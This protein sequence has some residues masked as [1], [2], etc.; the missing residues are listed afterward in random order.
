MALSPSYRAALNWYSGAFATA[1][2]PEIGLVAEWKICWPPVARAIADS[3][4][5]AYA[6]G[7]AKEDFFT[8]FMSAV[9]CKVFAFDP[10]AN[11]KRH[12]MP[13]VEFHHWGLRTGA[14]NMSAEKAFSGLYGTTNKGK[15]LS[16]RELQHRLGHDDGR[17]ITLM[18]MD[19]EGCEWEVWREIYATSGPKG[20][21][22]FGQILTELH[23]ASTLRF[24][25]AK[26]A[27]M[28]PLWSELVS[29][30]K[31]AVF[32]SGINPGAP[33]DQNSLDPTVF[34]TQGRLGFCCRE[35]SLASPPALSVARKPGHG[36][37]ARVLPAPC[38]EHSCKNAVTHEARRSAKMK[39]M[40]A[41]ESERHLHKRHTPEYATKLVGIVYKYSA[42]VRAAAVEAATRL[43]TE[44]VERVER[45]AESEAPAAERLRVGLYAQECNT[46]STPQ[47][48][49][50]AV[51]VLRR[52]GERRTTTRE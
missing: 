38:C 28:V 11:H 23:F 18:K 36:R 22:P 19:C 12:W 20:L 48:S 45:A 40:N 24:T 41:S 50:I 25:A 37:A 10:S 17:H 43:K 16:L 27:K 34:G 14:A 26:A 13:N 21:A 35:L 42:D 44:G 31:F 2:C 33:V 1:H 49:S 39:D 52:Y 9:G 3:T 5:I 47:L 30:S 4:C 8:E 6:F 46:A 32:A 29:A 15:Y 51:A 7:V